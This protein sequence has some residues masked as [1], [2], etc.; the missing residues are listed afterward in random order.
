MIPKALLGAIS[1]S[2]LIVLTACAVSPAERQALLKTRSDQYLCRNHFKQIFK[3]QIQE[4][5]DEIRSRG[6]NCPDLSPTYRE[7]LA[8]ELAYDQMGQQFQNTFPALLQS[9]G[10]AAETFII[11]GGAMSAASTPRAVGRLPNDDIPLS[12]GFTCPLRS[13]AASGVYRN[14]SYD[15][16]GG[17]V[18]QSVNASTFCP[19]SIR[20]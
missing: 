9:A 13:S 11:V 10:Q 19:T 17:I 3:W 15:C 5:G 4:I 7:E 12:A 16:A 14:C 2:W 18:V 20:R 8:R 6:I 1:I